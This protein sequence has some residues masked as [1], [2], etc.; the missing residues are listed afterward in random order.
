[1]VPPIAA[2]RFVRRGAPPDVHHG[3][4]AVLPADR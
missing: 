4:L 3:F 2:E 1:M